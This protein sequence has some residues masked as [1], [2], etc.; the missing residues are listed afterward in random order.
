M[1]NRN[2]FSGNKTKNSSIKYFIISFAVFIVV[3]AICS[4]LLFMKSLD[5]DI[6]NL[7][8]NSSTTT[9]NE[10]D[11]NITKV[12]S[13]NELK[14]KSNLLFIV[15]EG[16]GIDFVCVVS[17]DFD[18]KSM[19]VKCIDGSEDLS[20]KNKTLKLSSIY[21]MD[22]QL[23]VNTALTYNF[24]ITTDK[25]VI[26]TQK[27]FEDVLNLFDGFAVNVQ[28]NIDYKSHDFNLN[29]SS[30]LQELSPDMTY[31]YMQI[32]NNSTRENIICDII[33]SVLVP[34]YVDN[35]EKLF[36]SFVN[37]CKTNISVIDYSESIDRLSTYC[38]AYD[39]FNPIV[40]DEVDKE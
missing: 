3:L 20:Y 15:E 19:K 39:K 29:L 38:Y 6:S 5:Y 34:D 12:N 26:F 8:D 11:E 16:E 25:Y 33:K 9:T 21:S 2:L 30:G 7:V 36:K 28:E 32:S 22:Y 17:T 40:F 37:L 18:N 24:G 27:Q 1:K 35:S 4:V 23:G 31:K 10:T 13:V 14:G